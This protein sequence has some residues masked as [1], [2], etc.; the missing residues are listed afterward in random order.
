M[1]FQLQT[2]KTDGQ[3]TD[4]HYQDI[5]YVIKCLLEYLESNSAISE[6]FR[7][8]CKSPVG[9]IKNFQSRE[10]Q[11]STLHTL[12]DFFLFAFFFFRKQPGICKIAENIQ[13]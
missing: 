9:I 5:F 3:T 11:P 2:K 12:F 8:F 10:P 13:K 4:R 1:E 6:Y 7:Q